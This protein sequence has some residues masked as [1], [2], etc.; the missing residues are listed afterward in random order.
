MVF[1]YWKSSV[2]KSSGREQMVLLLS[3]IALS[4]VLPFLYVSPPS[5]GVC[6]FQRMGIWICVS[7][8][9]GAVLV[10]IVHVY[11]IFVSKTHVMAILM[12]AFAELAC[13]FGHKMSVIFFHSGK[14]CK[15]HRVALTAQ[16]KTPMWNSPPVGPSHCEV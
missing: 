12:T 15:H 11:R 13:L 4:F 1:I 16:K 6:V 2:I 3:G 9:F 10:K 5:L 8:T 7:F 14:K